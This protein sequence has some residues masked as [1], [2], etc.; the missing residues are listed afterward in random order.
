MQKNLIKKGFAFTIILLL[1]AMNIT[2]STGTVAE[3]ISTLSFNSNTLYVGGSG[4]GNYSKINDAYNDAN[5]GDT[6]FVYS[7]SY[8]EYL[9]IEK[10]INL[11][12]ED[13]DTT[14]IIYNHKAISPISIFTSD[15]VVSGFTLYNPNPDLVIYLDIYPNNNYNSISNC[16]FYNSPLHLDDDTCGLA[17]FNS[18]YNTISN[19]TFLYNDDEGI[20]LNKA[21]SHNIV[22]NCVF[23]HCGLGIELLNS[24]H[25]IINNCIMKNG[26]RGIFIGPY[27]GDI[28][29][30][31]NLIK[32]CDIYNNK[33]HGISI[34]EAYNN[35]IYNCSLD[36][37]KYY[38]IAVSGSDSYNNLII[39]NSIN[40]AER[41]LRLDF[42]CHNNIFT[43]NHISNCKNGVAIEE[44][45]HQDCIDN[46]FYHNNFFFITTTSLII[47]GMHMTRAIIFGTMATHQ[48]ETT[49]MITL[50]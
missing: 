33:Q 44:T 6:I 13:E 7:G 40:N 28:K 35:V 34:S 11:I 17:L 30:N 43:N 48:V 50:V 47:I 4:P 41:G 5:P 37:N 14:S 27:Y 1:I 42:F 21:S 45:F 12:G 3:K 46:L 8:N 20:S 31:N 16:I 39:I 29:S 2:S 18:S 10:T 49:G 38:G 19:C 24:S 22:E 15:V 23:S 9:W 36:N 32:N 25:N 26:D